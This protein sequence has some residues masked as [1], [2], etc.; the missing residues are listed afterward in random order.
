MSTKRKSDDSI[1]RGWIRYTSALRELQL[2][3]DTV[4]G[5]SAR[6][7]CPYLHLATVVTRMCQLGLVRECEWRRVGGSTRAAVYAADGGPRV[8]RVS[9]KLAAFSASG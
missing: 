8:P 5:L 4:R 1:R 9:G 3:P 7:G 2:Q 6:L